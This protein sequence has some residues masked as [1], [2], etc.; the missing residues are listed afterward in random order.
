TLLWRKEGQYWKVVAWELEPEE[1]MPNKSPDM[2][3]RRSVARAA[4]VQTLA[5]ADPEFAHASRDFLH[6][7][8]VADNFDHAATYFSPRSDNCVL[9]YLPPDKPAPSTSVE[10]AA[11]LRDAMTTV[12]KEV[13][14][15]QHLRDAM[16][17]A[18]PEHEDLKLVR[19]EG[20]GAYTVVAVP[21]YLA[22]LFLC[23]QESRKHPYTV[24]AGPTRKVYGNYYAVLFSLHTPGEH[25]A[26]LTLLWTKENGRWKIIAYE[27]LAP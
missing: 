8:L 24:A 9:A 10:Y 5:S 25:D 14:P 23:E 26:A 16:E 11:Y 17:P 12:G 27:L 6:S 2:H 4:A 15:I 13:G 19:S 1:V 18:R 3:R 22:D 7:W 20:E 21:D